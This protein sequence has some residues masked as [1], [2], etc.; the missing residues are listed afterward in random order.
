MDLVIVRGG[1]GAY[2]GFPEAS[3]ARMT[4]SSSQS[5]RPTLSDEQL[6]A[7]YRAG[8]VESLEL[9]IHR[10]RNELFNLLFRFTSDRNAAEDVFQEA[11]MQVHQSADT[12]DD[13]R[14]FKP[15][16]FTIAAN[17]ARDY[18]RRRSRRA[19]APLDAPVGGAGGEE[20]GSFVDLLQA[21]LPMPDDRIQRQELQQSVQRIIHQMPDHLRE[22]LILAYFQQLSYNDIAEMLDIPLGTVKSRLHTAVATFAKSWK[23]ANQPASET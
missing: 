2:Y 11:F 4:P 23:R 6:F 5:E 10:Y 19:T 14:T 18:M 21:D 9:L 3:I 1:N 15:W 7:Q 17:K 22:I 13:T 16:L 20:T 12:F 8:R